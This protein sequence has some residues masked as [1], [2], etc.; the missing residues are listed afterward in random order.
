[1][2][3]WDC[4]LWADSGI[5]LSWIHELAA[6]WKP[7]VGEEG[8]KTQSN[9]G[10]SQLRHCYIEENTADLLTPGTSARKSRHIISFGRED[11]NGYSIVQ[12]AGQSK[13]SHPTTQVRL[14]NSIHRRPYSTKMYRVK[15]FSAY[16]DTVRGR[17]HSKILHG[18]NNSFDIVASRVEETV[19]IFQ[20]TRCKR[21]RITGLGIHKK[22]HTVKKNAV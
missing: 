15:H 12:R 4:Y 14:R 5:A 6:M 17:A 3:S 18:R 7:F 16:N 8:E 11:L 1:M 19:D 22:A 9:S 10:P 2:N 13:T 21:P 20:M